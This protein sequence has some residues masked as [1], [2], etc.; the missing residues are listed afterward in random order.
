[1]RNLKK[2]SRKELRWV[3]GGNNA[4]NSLQDSN[5]S[6]GKAYMCCNRKGCSAC[7][8]NSEP[9]CIAGAWAVEC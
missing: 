6:T 7:V 2:I 5:G 8:P 9:R 1:M 4:N 3:F